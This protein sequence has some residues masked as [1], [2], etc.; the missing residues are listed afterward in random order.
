MGATIPLHAKQSGYYSQTRADLIERLRKPVGRVLDVGCGEGGAAAALRAA[1]ASQIVGIELLPEPAA[2]AAR[3][4]DEVL[5]GD[6]AECLPRLSGAFDTLLANDVLEHLYDP[7]ALLEGLRGVA[8]PGAWL[9]VSVPN[10]S[11]VSLLGDLIFRGTF[12]YQPHGHRD[13]THLRW[14][15]RR[16]IAALVTEAGWT[17]LGT[18]PAALGP[19]SRALARA[20]R[21]RSSEFFAAQWHVVA[22]NR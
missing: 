21:G 3:A 13:A 17:V 14:F 20:T 15:T 18:H 5:V 4:Y 6:A 19:P 7:L 8:A 12:N 9:N 2:V 1:D 22:E 16:D 10:A 11:H